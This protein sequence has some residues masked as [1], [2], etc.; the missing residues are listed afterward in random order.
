M[1][2]GAAGV[3]G[4]AVNNPWRINE[5]DGPAAELE[6]AFEYILSCVCMSLFFVRACI[7]KKEREIKSKKVGMIC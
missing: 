4:A 6:L 1:V 3:V 7:K 5:D 2:T